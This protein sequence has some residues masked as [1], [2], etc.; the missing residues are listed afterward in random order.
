MREERLYDG[1]PSRKKDKEDRSENGVS[2]SW[3]VFPNIYM[4]Y[5]S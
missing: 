1:L 2:R 4:V 3:P 5:E